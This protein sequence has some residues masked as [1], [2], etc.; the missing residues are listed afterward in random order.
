MVVR[1]GAGLLAAAALLVASTACSGSSATGASDAPTTAAAAPSPSPDVLD[2]N[3]PLTQPYRT[4]EFEPAL[5][6]RLP[7]D[8]FT[9]ERDV[10]A[11]QMYAGDEDY[12]ITFGHDSPRKETVAEAIAALKKT[13]GIEAG[14]VSPVSVGGRD[15]MAFVARRPGPLRLTFAG[16]FHVPGD[17]DLEVMA[18]S[19]KDGTT[20]TV[21]I[22]RR[23][24][25]GV[26]RS[27]DSIRRL[28]RRILATVQWR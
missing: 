20:L 24:D 11:F 9:A 16:G 4:T 12:E 10:S 2:T 7:A 6:V 23:V 22:T 27:L 14:P 5:S 15:G 13:E 1:R 26:A 28:A 25:D 17:S 21:F 18:V 8:W 3:V 19:L